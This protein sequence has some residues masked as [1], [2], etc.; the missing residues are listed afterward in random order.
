MTPSNSAE[1]NVVAGL[2]DGKHWKRK[3]YQMPDG[4]VHAIYMKHLA[5][6]EAAEKTKSESEDL[7]F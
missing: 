4:Q 1:R 5:K 2:Y 6:K 7:G 3:V